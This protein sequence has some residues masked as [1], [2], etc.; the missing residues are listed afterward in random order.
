MSAEKPS[1]LVVDDEPFNRDLIKRLL[2]KEGYENV[3]MAENG[4][5]A[6]DLLRGQPFDVVMLDIEMPELDGYG[7]LEEL[8]SDMGLR[9]IPV[10][11][12][13]SI[14]DVDSIVKCI[15]L[16]A[17]D[18]LPKPFNPTLLRARLGACLEKKRLRDLEAAHMDQIKTEKKRGD[19]LLS[20]IL[21]S[22][23]ASELMATGKV[24]PRGFENVAVLFCDIVGF[25]TFCNDHSPDEVVT[26]LQA[27]ITK[28]EELT[29]KY[30]ME[31]IKTIGDE[32]MA[33]AGLMMPNGEPLL[34]AVKCGL[35]M[36]AA[37]PE[38]K[39]DWQVRVGVHLGP[40]VAGIVG[41]QKYQFDIW[42]DT[43]N[44][45]ARMTSYGNP[46]VVTM[47]Y[48]SWLEVQG[49]CRGKTLGKIEV[50]GKGSVEVVECHGLS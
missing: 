2:A 8:K 16:G 11:M 41:D 1:L 5:Q 30:Q 50:K 14:D 43:V 32:Y 49:E 12:I 13:S 40:V 27:L 28:F 39:A 25:T 42:G 34:S 48:D 45:A 21:P 37:A 9:H 46:G 26:Y 23:A 22:A 7:V 10:I 47:T 18:Y 4:R 20:V 24:A 6:L 38:V 3:E 31:K 19:K 17:E 36:T 33:T 15:E 29:T 44:V 35:E